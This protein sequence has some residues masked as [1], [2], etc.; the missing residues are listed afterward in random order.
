MRGEDI[1]HMK[2]LEVVDP[3]LSREEAHEER[4]GTDFQK[5]VRESIDNMVSEIRGK[6]DMPFDELYH[7][8]RNIV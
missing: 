3:R 5:D 1:D 4:E 8:E 6:F 2:L 7:K